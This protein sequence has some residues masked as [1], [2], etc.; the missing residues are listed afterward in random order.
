MLNDNCRP[1]GIDLLLKSRFVLRK[2]S[3]MSSILI[4]WIRTNEATTENAFF[5]CAIF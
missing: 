4:R 2:S 5:A 1:G 3:F